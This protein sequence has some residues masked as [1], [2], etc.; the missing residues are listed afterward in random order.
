VHICIGDVSFR[1]FS[2]GEVSYEMVITV[3][4]TA[5]PC[6][7]WWVI[8]N[9]ILRYVHVYIMSKN[10]H[11]IISIHLNLTLG[12]CIIEFSKD[13]QVEIQSVPRTWKSAYFGDIEKEVCRSKRVQSQ[14]Y[15]LK[16]RNLS[17][18]LKRCFLRGKAIWVLCKG[19]LKRVRESSFESDRNGEPVIT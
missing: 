11:V 19:G 15:V 7:K 4:W 17:K 9:L 6:I 14:R 16:L 12:I 5:L 10:I 2:W 18:P 3:L 1:W 8:V 13:F